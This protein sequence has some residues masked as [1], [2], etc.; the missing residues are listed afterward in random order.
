MIEVSPQ[1]GGP[2]VAGDDPQV[3]QGGV[4]NEL[5]P[6]GPGRS[7]S[8]KPLDCARLDEGA[9]DAKSAC[10]GAEGVLQLFAPARVNEPDCHPEPP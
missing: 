10:V 2:V 3:G 4:D 5:T 9:D 6:W 8:K 1:S 7:Q